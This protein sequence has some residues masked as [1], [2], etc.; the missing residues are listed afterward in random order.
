MGNRPSSQILKAALLAAS[1]SFASTVPTPVAAQTG[2]QSGVIQSLKIPAGPLRETIFAIAQVYNVNVLVADDLIAGR[3]AAALSGPMSADQALSAA[4]AGTGLLANQEPDG[5][6]I[7]QSQP[8]SAMLA[9]EDAAGVETIFIVATRPAQSV[10]LFDSIDLAKDRGTTSVEE[11]LRRAANINVLGT[12]NGF[13]NIRGENAEG[14]GNSAQGIIPGQLS[15]TP[16]T[17]DRRPLAYGEIT[18]G[19]SSV[20]DVDFIEV[21]RGPQTTGGGVNGSI[22]AVNVTTRD[23]SSEFEAEVQ[24]EYGT[25]DQYQVAGLLSGALIE[26]ELFARVVVDYNRRDT[27][28]EYTNPNVQTV[29]QVFFLDQLTARGKL[30]WTPAALEDL[31]V[32]ASY[33]YTES[34][35]PQ[36]ENVTDGPDTNF[37]RN[38]GNIPAFFNDAHIGII[39]IDYEITPAILLNNHF[40]ISSS[41]L[42]RRSG[43]GTFRLDQDT[44]DIQ[45]ETSLDIVSADGRLEV[46]P[47][48]ILRRQD[49]EMD[50]DY[51]GPTILDDDRGTLGIYAQG[52]YEPLDGL[53]LAGGLRYERSSQQRIGVLANDSTSNPT[54]VDFDESFDAILPRFGIEYDVNDDILIGA[55]A[56][57]GF[58]PGGF[59]FARPANGQGRG[60]GVTPFGLPE[61]RRE[62]RWTYEA[63]ARSQFLDGK[64]ELLFNVF[65]N[66]IK[67]AQL[68]E[69]IEFA[70]EIFGSIVRNAEQVETYGFEIATTVRPASWIDITGSIGL[71][72]TEISEFAEAPTVEGNELERAP[73]F[74][75]NL[76]IDIE[77][78]ENLLIGASLSYVDGYFSAFDND[79]LEKTDNRTLV[80]LRASY[81][82]TPNLEIYGIANNVF[83]ERALTELFSATA[84]STIKPQEFVIGA[85]VSF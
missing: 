60:D 38:S 17:I 14:A 26:D 23:P 84:G 62:I 85:R 3:Q 70:P 33:S 39:E 4:L 54:D 48:I 19:T 9:Q 35:G 66:D 31:R 68:V 2:V 43:N 18:F 47:G 61:F 20:Y 56:A 36:T 55:F 24:G 53:R 32:E 57:R 29:D 5:D 64:L 65:F 82:I 78:I 21:V 67:D 59:S 10:V 28:L 25:F 80:D 34:A 11:V 6:Y 71:L 27:Y 69:S 40:A 77:P 83:D 51:F 79:P 30:V 74:T 44:L 81:Q 72:E 1:T 15:P 46:S 8:Q 75:A 45:N 16:V 7:V 37:E 49:V 58:T 52:S 41:D 73:G 12:Q 42:A 50:W 22:G 76:N 13:I 63:Y